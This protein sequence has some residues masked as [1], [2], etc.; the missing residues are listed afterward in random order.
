VLSHSRT[1]HIP[2]DRI[3]YERT[4][5]AARAQLDEAAFNAAWDAGRR[6]TIE[7]AIAQAEQIT[8]VADTAFNA[9][10]PRDPNALTVREREV[11]RLV[12][13]GLSD[14]QI[15][16]QLVISRR[17]VQTHLTSIFG[18]FGVNSRSAAAHHALSRK[19]L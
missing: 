18:K 19:L 8:A 6:L 16:T 4:L 17:T 10:P 15:A 13:T 12:A 14:A 2:I 11:L 7:Q 5:A 9:L 3:R 1:S